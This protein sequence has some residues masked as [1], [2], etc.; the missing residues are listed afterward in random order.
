PPTCRFSSTVIFLK[1]LRPSGTSAM[2]ARAAR[3]AGQPD[4]SCPSSRIRPADGLTSPMIALMVV[5]LPAPL[6]PS[7]AMIW[8]FSTVRFT[9][10]STS[11]SPYAACRFSTTSFIAASADELVHAE[12]GA[13][14][15]GI[16]LRR[17]GRPGEDVVPLID[18]GHAVAKPSDQ[19]EIVL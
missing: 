4:R 14:H 13:H 11:I 5:L 15:F 9:P 10:C 1:I 18:D 17:R 2:P 7:S 6:A 8:P 19:F 12:I 3:C 16:P